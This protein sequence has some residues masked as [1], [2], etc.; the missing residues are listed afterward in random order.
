[1]HFTDENRWLGEEKKENEKA[2]PGFTGGLSLLYVI[3]KK[4]RVE[5]GL[6][7]TATNFRYKPVNL[8]WRGT[9]ASLPVR[10]QTKEQ[11]QHITI[12]VKAQIVI[13]ER[14]KFIWF[15]SGGLALNKFLATR[16]IVTS[17][18]DDGSMHHL[19]STRRMGKSSTDLAIIVGGGVELQLAKRFYLK[20]EPF[21]RHSLS[22]V[23][24]I[25]T[26]KEFLYAIGVN[27]GISY[28]IGKL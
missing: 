18:H 5:T 10:S 17:E 12:P 16:F 9:V 1:L 11:Y 8:D 19:K 26:A 13:G 28:S 6:L 27:S 4:I 21:F 2:G 3:N 15:A 22:S 14:G 20:F 7:F 24:D 23:G 25:K